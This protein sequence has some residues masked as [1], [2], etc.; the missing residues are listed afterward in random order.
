MAFYV[1]NQT[2][3][4]STAATW[5][6]GSNTPTLHASTNITPTL[7]GVFSAAFTAPN[8]TGNQSIGVMVFC[9]TKAGTGNWTAT[10]QE[11]AGAGF[12][13]VAGATA[14]VTQAALIAGNFIYFQWGTPYTYAVATAGKYRIKLTVSVATSGTAAADSGGS[15]FMYLEVSDIGGPPALNDRAWIVTPNQTTAVTVTVDGVLGAVGDAGTAAATSPLQRSITEAVHINGYTASAGNA[16]L[17]WDTAASATL[18]VKGNIAVNSGGELQMGTVATPYDSAYVATLSFNQN[19]ATGTSGGRTFDGGRTIMQGTP[20]P[21]TTYWKKSYVSGVGTAADPMI[22]SAGT[23]WTVNDE[24][25]IT[26][27]AYNTIE[28]KFIKTVNSSTSYVLSDTAGG[29][30]SAL[31]NAHTSNDE[32]LVLARNVIITG[33][34]SAYGSYW[35]N[36]SL[37]AGDVNIDWVKVEYTGTTI[38]N[39][40]GFQIVAP[41]IITATGAL[42]YSVVVS[43]TGRGFMWGLNNATVQTHTGLIAVKVNAVQAQNVGT[44][45]NNGN[46]KTLVDCYAV[47]LRSAGFELYGSSCTY[48]RCKAIGNNTTGNASSGGMILSTTNINATWNDC[49]LQANRVQGLYVNANVIRCTANDCLFGTKGTNTTDVNLFGGQYYDITFINCTLSSA[50]RVNNYLNMASGALRFHELNTVDNTHIWYTEKGT[51]RSCGSGLADTT[52]RTPNSL[53][54]GLYPENASGGFLWPFNIYASA[55]SIA[56]FFGYFK[57][58]A[59]FTGDAGAS[60]RVELWLPGSSVADASATLSKLTNDWQAVS[61]SVNNTNTVDGLAEIRVY[62]ISATAGAYLYADDFYNAGDTVT[63]SDKVT[64]LDTWYQGQP[65]SIISPKSVSAADIWTFSTTALTTANTTGKTLVDILGKVSLN[66]ALII[67]K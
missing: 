65:V 2:G 52:V 67:M 11:D 23:A 50:T 58:N 35:Y 38:A 51:A 64:G 26:N 36:G 1:S 24:I 31:A 29:A 44:I 55:L 12:A 45:Y 16:L 4:W 66:Q 15:N 61:L 33:T 9:A 43:P 34:D 56:N 5:G 7:T 39:K 37:T 17:K 14:T 21:D 22:V 18:T 63:N 53:A 41:S 19:G 42:D 30:E 27:S 13:D 60:A 40:F 10:L 28:Y 32:I 20:K 54:V 8:I 47:G 25:V 62:A 49:E 48:T 3:N 59:A 57:L 46:N 6:K